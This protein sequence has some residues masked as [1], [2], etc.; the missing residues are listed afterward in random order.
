MNKISEE[1]ARRKYLKDVKAQVA[2]SKI[3]KQNQELVKDKIPVSKSKYN[4]RE[5]SAKLASMIHSLLVFYFFGTILL[6]S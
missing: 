1:R 4:P 5:A 3:K 2:V 6:S